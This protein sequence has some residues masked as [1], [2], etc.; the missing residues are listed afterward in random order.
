MKGPVDGLKWER[1]PARRKGFGSALTRLCSVTALAVLAGIVAMC[2][3]LPM[4]SSGAVVVKWAA[5]EWQGLPKEPPQPSIPGRTTLL[6]PTGQVVAQVF[7]VNRIP[8]AAEAQSSYL[9]R[10]VVA[11]EDAEFF[12]HHGV[13]LRGTARAGIKTLTHSG[14]Q[15]GSTITQ[16]YVKNLRLTQ[17]LVDGGGSTDS[18][19]VMAAT[20][21]SLRRKLIEARMAMKIEATT[22]KE[23]IL[24]GYLNVSY[25]GQGAF[26]AEA[27]ANRYFSKSAATL[28]IPQ[29]ALL[30]GL[31]QSPSRYDPIAHPEAA[32]SRRAQVIGRMRDTGVI[33]AA[34]AVAAQAA[35]IGLNPSAPRQGC[36]AARPGWAFVC[37][38]ALRELAGPQWAGTQARQLLGSGGLTV[39]LTVDP[40]AQANANRAA[41]HIIPATHRVA[42]AVVMVEP[43]TGRVLAIGTN[44]RF[45]VGRGRTEIPL[46]T[47]A[48]FSPGSTFK[49]FTLTAALEAGI[50]LSTRLPAGSSYYSDVFD[51]PPGGYHNAE[52]LSGSNVTI[53]QA[54][55]RSLNTAYVQLAERVGVD[56][57][58]DAARR[59]GIRSVP[60]P[61]KRRAPGRK[62]G[63][64]VLGARDVSVMDMAGAYAA[65]AAHGRW[66]PPHVVA[67]VT[68]PGGTEERFAEGSCRQ[69]VAAPVADTISSV[70]G[71]VMTDGT[72]KAAALPERRPAAGKT[73]TS[74][75]A[76]AAWFAGFTPQ[77]AAAVWTGDPRS[78]RNTLH[79]V[80]GLPIVYGG[81]LPAR[82]WKATLSAY[83]KGKPVLPLP[84]VDSAY[85]LGLG[86]TSL[87]SVLVPDV[88]GLPVDVAAARL[89]AAGLKSRADARAAG[90]PIPA[91][92]VVE[93]TPRAGVS[94]AAGSEVK[95][96]VSDSG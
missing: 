12:A 20:E 65:I 25:L 40:G 66:C 87:D 9:R 62:E 8:V 14:I 7:A 64:F 46:A 51:N 59:L 16:Q 67:T 17:A 37:D 90:P 41:A 28:D 81:T 30:A 57:V 15:G 50:P 72:G 1:I 21:N 22:T 2:G 42:N 95:L 45:G 96:S 43:G 32:I 79:D 52:G 31:L 58:A 76:G 71:G 93:Q 26:G 75:D 6:S 11:T 3:V 4:A 5:R 55:Q 63:S 61:R 85:L 19:Q 54:T 91:G 92:V 47:T 35:P 24:T 36:E 89:T 60:A 13:D 48:S 53:P 86:S 70:L 78:P 77:A 94:T 80:L 29:A 73:G 82:L 69:A 38:A 10:A 74:E 83:L 39:R 34:Q 18:P 56:A 84:G 68:T 23:D 44:R 33:T 49:L 27:A 88:V